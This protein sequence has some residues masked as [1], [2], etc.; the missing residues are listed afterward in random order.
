MVYVHA[1]ASLPP[2]LNGSI[3]MMTY[4]TAGVRELLTNWLQ[5]V[6]RLQLPILVAAMDTG[7]ISQCRA[8]RFQC[9]DWSSTATGLDGEYVPSTS[10]SGFRALGRRKLESLLFILQKGIDVVMSDADCVWLESPV[11]M[12]QGQRPGYEDYAHA[13]LIMTTDCLDPSEDA[14]G[15]GCFNMVNAYKNTGVLAVRSTAVAIATLKEWASR[16]E[17]GMRDDQDQT[18]FNELLDGSGPHDR[19]RD[20]NSWVVDEPRRKDFRQFAERW[21]ARGPPQDKGFNKPWKGSASERTIAPRRPNPGSRFIYD[22]CLPNVSLSLLVGIFSIFDVTNGH[23]F[24]VQQL[25]L[26]TARSPL[27][28]HATHTFGDLPDFPYGKRQR[29]RDWGLWAV[30]DEN[31]GPDARYLVLEDAGDGH[32]VAEALNGPV[33]G[34]EAQAPTRELGKASPAAGVTANTIE[35]RRP[36]YHSRGRWHVLHITQVRQQLAHAFALARALNRIVVLPR[37][38]CWCDK[39]WSRLDD[40]AM[41]GAKSSQP[42]P[43]VCP[44]DHVIDPALLHGNSA[45][46]LA[47]SRRGAL[48][49]RANGKWQ[50]GV[51]FRGR[52][53]LRTV[54]TRPQ[55]ALSAASLV[56][57][58]GGGGGGERS[59]ALAAAVAMGTAHQVRHTPG[60][61]RSLIPL[62][63][64]RS[65]V[66][67]RDALGAHGHV[68]LLHVGLSDAAQLLRCYEAAQESSDMARLSDFL[69]KSQTPSNKWCYRPKEMPPE[70]QEARR[71]GPKPGEEPWC[72]WGFERPATP[73][74]CAPSLEKPP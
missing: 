5:H 16:M 60:A 51:P 25:Q 2:L 55:L 68:R 41:P 48:A 69:F 12:I 52:N 42:L 21:C 45:S 47:R 3:L 32:E 37:V 4:A 39:H 40:C 28:V 22:V 1:P 8:E 54:G 31:D 56:V 46:R 27:A 35:Q 6:E 33:N 63:A 49:A 64:G 15:S 72:V 38:L 9:L 58:A 59:R 23:T 53:W 62:P 50:E 61:V 70:W 11:P 34:S 43:F 14:A 73:G 26:A 18:I 24:F 13:D 57:D 20:G 29:L 44:L 30:E 71:R 66:Q 19:H 17:S 74:V 65:D 67:L 10:T 7:V 36:D